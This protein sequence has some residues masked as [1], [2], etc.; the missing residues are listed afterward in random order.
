[1]TI[2]IYQGV[3]NVDET[4][5]KAAKVLGAKDVDIF[6]KVITAATIP[7]IL[8]AVRLG[9]SGCGKSTLLNMIAD[10]SEPT[11]GEMF[12]DGK[13]VVGTRSG[14]RRGFPT[15]RIVSLAYSKKKCNVW[16]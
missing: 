12:C 15:I 5:V 4:L 6:I 11:S 7:F 3:L 8:T 2:T 14:K 9:P 1:M 13:K 16:T 10:L